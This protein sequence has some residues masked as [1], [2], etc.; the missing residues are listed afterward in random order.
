MKKKIRNQNDWMKYVIF[1][2]KRRS[3]QSDAIAPT[4]V[5]TLSDY[6][7]KIGDAATVTFTFS[8]APTGFTEADVTAPNGSLSSFGV[9]G[10][11]LIYTAVFTPTA[12]VTDATNV[13]TVGTG[14]TDAAGNP[15]AGATTSSN[16]TVDTTAPT[17]TIAVTGGSP[18][19]TLPLTITFTLSKPSTDFA[20]GDVTVGGGTIAN[21][22]GSGIAYTC[23][24]TPTTPNGTMTF[25]VAADVFH[26]AAGNGNIA[27][28]Q[29]SVVSSAFILADEFTD[30]VAAGSVN[31]TAATPTGGARTATDANSKINVGSGVL[32]FATGVLTNDGVW[33]PSSARTAGR[34]II[35]KITPA[36]TSGAWSVGFDNSAVA[37][38]LECVGLIT[39]TGIRVFDNTNGITV[40]AYSSATAYMIAG[41]QRATGSHWFIKGGAFTNWTY[42]YNIKSLTT[43]PLFPA[44]GNRTTA[45]VST[46]DF[47]RVPTSLITITPLASDAF[48]RADGVL[49][50]TGGGG[51]EESGG[52]GLAWTVQKGTGAI[53][54]NKGTFS[55]LTDSLGIA[56]VDA[57]TTNITAEVVATRAA[58][59]SGLILRWTDINNYIKAVLDG[60]NLVVTEV[61]AGTPNVLAT[62]AVTYGATKRLIIF[63]NATKIRAYYGDALIGSELT[64]AVTS[65]N[66]H[67]LFTDDIGATFDNF[68]IFAKGNGG[69]YESVFNKYTL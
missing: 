22:A 63:L 10:N 52:S 50:S 6:A 51:S 47:V 69:E 49:G 27:A 18:N 1:L 33:W 37:A 39:T 4:V 3:R 23:E 36:D 16:Y 38:H 32:S 46:V 35:A 65:G 58:G 30:T 15:P 40:A 24:A 59:T 19:S 41:V 29:L 42:L 34:A 13:I 54:T 11:P 62:T 21:F 9:T 7:L 68:V 67:G 66:A 20:V 12:S 28:S 53:A 64:T 26:D 8:E 44:V 45:G 48:T 60:T 5:I 31:G 56:T 25:D 57:G 55:A 43:T 14:W 17:C 2:K 61:V